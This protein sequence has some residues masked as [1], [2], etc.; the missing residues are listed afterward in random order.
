MSEANLVGGFA[1]G[2]DDLFDSELTGRFD[3]IISGSNIST[4]ALIV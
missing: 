2:D 3:D 1:A 4:V